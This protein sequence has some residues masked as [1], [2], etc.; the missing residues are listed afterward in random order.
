MFFNVLD[1]ET[2]I[3]IDNLDK[4]C[5]NDADPNALIPSESELFVCTT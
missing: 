5:Y 3:Y 1:E 2:S 4:G